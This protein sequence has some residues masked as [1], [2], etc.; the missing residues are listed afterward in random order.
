MILNAAFLF[1]V[2]SSLAAN[3]LSSLSALVGFILLS[4]N[5]AALGPAFR[6]CDLTKEDIPEERTYHFNSIDSVD[7]SI[8][9]AILAVS[10]FRWD[11][12]ILGGFWKP[13]LLV[14]PSFENLNSF[15]LGQLEEGQS[16]I[17]EGMT[18]KALGSLTNRVEQKRK[19]QRS[20]MMKN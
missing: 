8:A 4:V 13:A 3:L 17:K 12:P 9:N 6:E 1:Q 19:C 2:Q 18:C 7:C 5:L 14:I 15:W 10:I 16:F 11:V 20:L